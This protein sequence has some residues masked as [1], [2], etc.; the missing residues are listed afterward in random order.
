M[1]T[2]AIILAAGEGKRMKSKYPKV[3]H[4]ICGKPMIHYVINCVRETGVSKLFVVVGHKSEDVMENIDESVQFVNQEQ[5][6]G[7]GHAVMQAREALRDFDGSV[8]I[9]CG[10]TPLITS[11]T[12]ETIIKAQK[13]R[14][15]A[16]VVLTTEMDDPT[17]YGRVIR[18]TNGNI[19][20]IVE[21]KDAVPAEKEI[22]EIN[23][24]IY[25]FDSRLLFESLDKLSCN[26]VQGEY[27]LTDVIEILRVS[28]HTVG[29][30]KAADPKELMGVNNKKELA[31][32]NRIMRSKILDKM[33]LEGVTII[34]PDKTYLDKDVVIGKDTIIYPGCF[35]EEGSIIGEDCII[36][37]NTKISNSKIGN[38]VVVE[39]SVVRESTIEDG[40]VVGPFANL[41]AGCIIG[42]GVK[43]GD[44]VEVKNSKI[45]HGAK[46]PHLSYIGDAEI[47]NKVNLGAG[48]II[49]NYDG[50]KKHLTKIGDN[51]FIGCNSNLVSPIEI[52]NDAYIAAGSTIT[53][54][55]PE[56]AL[57]IARSKQ[58]NK[59]DWVTRFREKKQSGG[60]E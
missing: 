5:Q 40:A 49:V 43:I 29:A 58:V 22:T 45:G 11:D 41:R 59:L 20:R 27:Y 13:E 51:S 36:G 17:G 52:G 38:R 12:I 42:K 28:G 19:E 7:T 30:V 4:K 2:A 53:S 56:K 14:D 33:M 18:D 1:N 34:D 9:L 31:E 47:G 24:G 6:L 37:P 46:L 16:C 21:E 10:D 55:V 26:N 8:L 23:S 57:S 39:Y 3:L 15:L 32:A 50:F 35:I 48:V 25:V 54:D 60:G 44:F